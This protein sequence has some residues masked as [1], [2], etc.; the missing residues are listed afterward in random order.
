M[1][2]PTRRRLER[3][4][5]HSPL[6]TYSTRDLDEELPVVLEVMVV[7]HTEQQ[8][9]PILMYH[10][11]SSYASP[12]F[13]PCIV[14]PE[15]FNQHLS[16][17]DQCHYSPITV[18]QFVQAMAREGDGLPPRPVILTFD[19]GYADFYTSAF[20]ALQRH[21]FTATLYVATAFVGGTSRWMQH[22][23]EGLRPMLTWAQL[24]EINAN[25]I[26]CGAHSHTHRPLDMLPPSV[27]HE[28]IVR[29]KELLEEY[30]G[31]PVSSFAYP[32]GY[33]SAH[34]QQIVQAVG[35]VSACAVKLALSSLYDDPY[36][37]ARLAI[38]PD[39]SV[40]DLGLALSHGSGP[41]V[42]SSLRR[43]RSRVRQHLRSAYGSLWSHFRVA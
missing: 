36:A 34:V 18:T 5:D 16:Y 28:E 39:T 13:R 1:V 2:S 3:C 11:I 12:R 14:S 6:T 21:V 20:P 15:T 22:I 37:L 42:T 4:N 9:I 29:S 19:D 43:V 24:A 25:G 38:N 32:Y 41:L 31:Q 27:A 17:L 7:T 8:N 30:L 33:Y 26:E 23:G 10:S 40:H 35:Y